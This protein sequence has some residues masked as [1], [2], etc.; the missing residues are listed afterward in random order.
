MLGV[1]A[2]YSSSLCLIEWPQ[3]LAGNLPPTYIAANFKLEPDNETR[4]IVFDIVLSDVD[5]AASLRD[6]LKEFGNA[7]M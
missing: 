7:K 1:P 2:I 3:R 4:K 5:R 6:I